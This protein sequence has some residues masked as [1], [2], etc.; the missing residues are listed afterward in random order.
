MVDGGINAETKKQVKD[1][2]ILASGSY[3][4]N[5]D[6]YQDAITKLRSI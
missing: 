2:D 6:D 1:A 5:S 4:L 3:I